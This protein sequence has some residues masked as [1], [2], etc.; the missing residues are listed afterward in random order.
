MDVSSAVAAV[1]FHHEYPFD[2]SYGLGERELLRV[3][4]PEPPRDFAAFWKERFENVSGRPTDVK[5][6]LCGHQAHGEWLI[7]ELRYRST[8]DFLIRGWALVPKEGEV[9]R[10]FVCLHGYGGISGPSFDLPLRDAVLFFP[11]L[12][13]I[14]ASRHPKISEDP[15]WHVLHDIDQRERYIHGGCVED[16]WLGVTALLEQFPQVEGRVGL[17]GISFGGGIGMLAMPWDERICRAHVEVPSFGHQALRLTLPTVGSGA[18]VIDFERKH[19]GVLDTLLYYDA[20][21][22]AR[23]TEQP[24]HVAAAL[25]DPMVAPP[26]QFAIYRALAGPREL[27]VLEA[28][29]YEYPNQAKQRKELLH[30]IERHFEPI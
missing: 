13:G 20:A 30:R 27:Y 1:P 9:R 2:P 29:H 24:V 18:A 15:R 11:C 19:G 8:D 28:G 23:F 5:L 25:F 7:S 14:S 12:R 6:T 4:P 10:G 17:L 21:H 3:E 26:G 16:T 22:A